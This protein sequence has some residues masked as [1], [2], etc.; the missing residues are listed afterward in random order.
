MIVDRVALLL[1]VV[2]IVR[3]VDLLANFA[4]GMKRLVPSRSAVFTSE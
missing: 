3:I 2:T 4:R 1:P